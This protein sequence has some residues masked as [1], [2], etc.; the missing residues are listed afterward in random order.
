MAIG[1]RPSRHIC[2]IIPPF[3][4]INFNNIVS[5]TFVAT[6]ARF[7]VAN[8]ED[9][10]AAIWIVTFLSLS[11]TTMTALMRGFIKLNMLDIDDG[12]ASLAQLLAY[13]NIFSVIYALRHGLARSGPHDADDNGQPDYGKVS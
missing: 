13:G 3:T 4:S 7:A 12:G 9:Q 5:K 1:V 11:Y 2:A 10:S 6:M 8:M